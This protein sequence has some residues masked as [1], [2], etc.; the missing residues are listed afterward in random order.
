MQK[1]KNTLERFGGLID[2]YT[3][4]QAV[5]D[6]SVVPLLYEGRHVDQKVDSESIDAWFDRITAKLSKEQRADLKEVHHHRPAQQ[7]TAE[8]HAYRLGC[9]YA[10]SRQLA[11]HAYKAQLVAQDKSTA[12]LYKQYLDEFGMVNSEVLISPPDDRQGNEEVEAITHRPCKPFWK[13]MMTRFG[14]EEV[15]AAA[16]SAFKHADR[17][18]SLSSLTCC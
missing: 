13:K 9:E 5:Q 11:G 10:L 15:Q 7:G 2:T 8:S 4:S 17:R 18:R 1:E 12:L 3:I 16:H 14:S 6:K